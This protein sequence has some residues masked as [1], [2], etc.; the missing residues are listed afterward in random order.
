VVP[1]RGHQL[2]CGHPPTCRSDRS[3][4]GQP[5]VSPTPRPFDLVAWFPRRPWAPFPRGA[6]PAFRSPWVARGSTVPDGQ[7]HPLRS[8][9]PPANP[10]TSTRANPRRRPLL[11]WVSSPS[12]TL[13]QAS[14]PRPARVRRPEL[15]PRAF[16]KSNPLGTSDREDP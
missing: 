3:L 10:F 6:S 9:P 5:P 4:P 11:S 13:T 16:P 12:E 2:P 1:S 15:P 14:E 7:L 8:V